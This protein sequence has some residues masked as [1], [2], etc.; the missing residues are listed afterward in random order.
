MNILDQTV[1]QFIHHH[2]KDNRVHKA[3]KIYSAI[4]YNNFTNDKRDMIDP[5]GNANNHLNSESFI[6]L[7]NGRICKA[8]KIKLLCYVPHGR[9]GLHICFWCGPCWHRLSISMTVPVCRF[10]NILRVYKIG[11]R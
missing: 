11:A 6:F 3:R 8:L 10:E 9:G 5:L 4:G 2:T 7:A 1:G